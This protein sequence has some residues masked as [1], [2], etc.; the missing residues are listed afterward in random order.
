MMIS[1][2]P[3]PTL[4]VFTLGP[5]CERQRRQ[6]LPGQ[7]GAAEILVHQYGL[8]AALD[9]GRRCGYRLVVASPEEINLPPDVEQVSQQGKGFAQRLRS[10]ISHFQSQSPGAPL[11]VVGT[12]VPNLEACHLREAISRLQ[13]RPEEVVLGPCPDGGFYLLATNSSVDVELGEVRWCQ[14]DTLASLRRALARHGRACS[15]LDPL[16]DL[17]QAGD[18]ELWLAKEAG[19]SSARRLARVLTRLLAMHRRPQVHGAMSELAPAGLAINAGR[20]PPF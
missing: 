10:T 11:L 18:L 4:L 2:S 16:R 6:L 7:H 8:A 3:R 9:A 14:R 12:D 17:D 20:A 5:E 19:R 15:L 13:A 1:S